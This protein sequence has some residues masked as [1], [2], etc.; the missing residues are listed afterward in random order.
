M[1]TLAILHPPIKFYHPKD[2]YGEFSNFFIRAITIEGLIWPTTEHYFQAMKSEDPKVQEHIRTL[3]S[4]GKAKNYGNEQL[5]L[6]EDW[7]DIVGDEK[8]G[9]LFRDEQGVVVERVKDHF[10]YGALTAK[11]EQHADLRKLLLGTGDAH[12]IEDTQKV[13]SDPYWGNGPSAIG[14]NKLGRM[15]VMLRAALRRRDAEAIISPPS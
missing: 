12:I 3:G 13:G 8:L 5:T 4:P 10:M 2:P 1:N 9:D 7:E 14:L 15:L 6:R 11:F